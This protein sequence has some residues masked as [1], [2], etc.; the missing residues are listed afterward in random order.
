M[1]N[2]KY[3]RKQKRTFKSLL[4]WCTY[5]RGKGF[6][7]F[8]LD[9]TS[10]KISP[11]EK[12]GENFQLLRRMIERKFKCRVLYFKIETSEG[13]GVYHM[14]VAIKSNRAVYIPQKWLSKKW[15]KLHMAPVVYIKRVSSGHR[16]LRNIGKYLMEQYLAGQSALLRVSWSWWRSGIT[17]SRAF[18]D[19]YCEAR[20][21]FLSG[22]AKGESRFTR[23][24]TYGEAM[25][26]WTVLLEKGSVVI[27]GAAFFVNGSN[28][29]DVA[30]L[31][32]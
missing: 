15:R 29:I 13:N 17:F 19:F 5:Y 3:S 16:N 11:R 8:R 14:V 20:N 2:K 7:L 28:E 6:Q 32:C 10:S 27:A 9:L 30:Y 24:I 22:C 12:M 23:I 1:K 21:A 18:S 4:S 26:A 25:R 31:E